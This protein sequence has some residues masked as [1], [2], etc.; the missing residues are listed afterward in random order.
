L[1]YFGKSVDTA[2]D[3]ALVA[4]YQFA[5]LGLWSGM[6]AERLQANVSGIKSFNPNIKLA[7]Y[8]MLA[9]RRDAT[10]TSDPGYAL[11]QSINTNKWWLLDASGKRTQW[12]T[13]YDAYQ[14]NVTAW[15]PKDSSGRTWAQVK[16]KYDTDT[17]LS[18]MKGL[19]Y[20]YLDGISDPVVSADWKRIGTNQP[21]TDPV[22]ISE[23]RKG[24]MGY[25]NELRRLN[26]TLKMIGNNGDKALKSAEYSG[27]LEGAYRECL[28][29]K[30][31]SIETWSSWEA[32]MN[33]YRTALA[34]TK[35]PKAVVFGVCSPEGPN[36]ALYRYGIA[37]AL[38]DD[39]YFS[40]ST[41]NLYRNMPWF[42]E[43]DAPLGT[44]AEAPPTAPTASGIWTRKYTNGMVLV[45]PSKTTA[46]TINVGAGYKHLK[47]TIDPVVNNGLAVSTVTLQPRSGL[48]LVRQQ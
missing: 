45:N 4:R 47:G 20:V 8:V 35:A 38:L 48:V 1:T 43:S 39:G 3:Q 31:W 9:E 28:M 7:Q 34:N 12:T 23:F 10:G 5:V 33:Y 36:A 19:D 41:D 13:A 44:A 27:Q 2:A 17:L 37:S 32:M 6:G 29:G 26:P 18:K 30:S 15:A 24:Y 14:L 22:V 40:F 21:A 42:D 46:A 25:V 11:W 16:A